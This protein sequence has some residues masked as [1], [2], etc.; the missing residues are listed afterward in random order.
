MNYRPRN[1][2]GRSNRNAII[3]ALLSQ[4][5][6]A[7]VF[8]L[9]AQEKLASKDRDY[10]FS[11]VAEISPSNLN[12][13]HL[14]PADKPPAR[15]GKLLASGSS[16]LQSFEQ[17]QNQNTGVLLNQAR[18]FSRGIANRILET[19]SPVKREGKREN[20]L[21]YLPISP[22]KNSSDTS[23][24]L[25]FKPTS[26]FSSLGSQTELKLPSPSTK[27]L[28][29]KSELLGGLLTLQDLNEPSMPPIAR[30]ER[31][32][33]SRSGDPLAP[34]PQIWREPMRKALHALPI[35]AGASKSVPPDKRIGSSNMDAARFVHVPSTKIR[36]ERE[37]PLALQ[38]DGTVD[39]LNRPDDPAVIEE[40]N[41][42]SL[43]QKP[44]AKGRVSPAIVHLHPISPAVNER[45]LSELKP[46][47]SKSS[48]KIVDAPT[49][50]TAVS[51]ALST[52]A[53]P[54]VVPPPPPP[55]ISRISEPEQAPVPEKTA[56]A[57]E[58]KPADSVAPNEVRP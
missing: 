38:A 49:S 5:I 26:P 20:M 11:R 3:Y 22:P 12:Q 37:I 31:V 55:T 48:S 32:Q 28:Y 8:I 25:H 34:L 9:E 42:W 29:S 39:I 18:Q 43:K 53:T 36:H 52:P 40:I 21:A 10:D 24:P 7:P 23:L 45:Q 50:P 56:M 51:P 2:Q 44:P 6:W 16:R 33:W 35:T 1:P 41:R 30:A 19:V 27:Q 13:E 14:N 54:E 47:D 46:V 4:I 17:V 15:T 58:Q 57:A